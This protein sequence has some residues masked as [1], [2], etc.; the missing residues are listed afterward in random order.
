MT[1]QITSL[2]IVYSGVYWGANQRKHQ[3]S[4]SLAFVRG[5]HRTPVNSPYKGQVTRK[6]FQFDDVIMKKIIPVCGKFRKNFVKP[7]L[8]MT[9]VG[10]CDL[11]WGCGVG[12]WGG[13]GWGCLNIYTL[14]AYQHRNTQ[15]LI[16]DCLFMMAIPPINIKCCLYI[17]T[18]SRFLQGKKPMVLNMQN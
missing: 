7:W 6:M 8:L 14:N 5:I 10:V 15:I 11:G 1:S 9:D 4:A 12:V 16:H 3:S 17:E 13:R 18:G 2:T